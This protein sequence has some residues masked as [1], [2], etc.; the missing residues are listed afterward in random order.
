MSRRY[1]ERSREKP[2]E[3]DKRPSERII[4]EARAPVP[5]VVPH[6]IISSK[7][8]SLLTTRELATPANT[9]DPRDQKI[10]MPWETRDWALKRDKI[11]TSI[12]SF[13]DMDMRLAWAYGSDYRT[14]SFVEMMVVGTAAKT[15]GTAPHWP[16]DS[17]LLT[18]IF[19][20]IQRLC[21]EGPSVFKG[22]DARPLTRGRQG[23]ITLSRIQAATIVALMWFN[24]F[25]YKFLTPGPITCNDFPIASMIGIVD[26]KSLFPAT[27]IF[28]YFT[29]IYDLWPLPAPRGISSDIDTRIRD[30]GVLIREMRARKIII[31]RNVLVEPMN[32]FE[33]TEPICTVHYGDTLD[34]EDSIS[35]ICAAYTSRFIGGDF[36]TEALS[37]DEIIIAGRPE[38]MVARLFC[39]ETADNEAI[40]VLGAERYSAYLGTASNIVHKGRF[41]DKSPIGRMG[42]DAL[43]QHG[44]VF[45]D[46]GPKTRTM[47]QF[48][49]YFDRDLDK[50]YAGFTSNFPDGSQI[51]CTRWNYKWTIL[52]NSLK[53]LQLLLAASAAK[54]SLV[55]HADSREFE[56][57][58][59]YFLAWIKS[60]NLTVGQLA[61]RYAIAIK[62]EVAAN[63]L[64]ASID[65]FELIIGG[66]TI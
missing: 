9:Y 29:T 48:V 61:E 55:Y 14:K 57:K 22:F 59:A 32:W 66:D 12:N 41:D 38:L 37:S 27:C 17:D 8:S 28:E 19:P 11:N 62:G 26:N 6:G 24:Q 35:T 5:R 15:A 25:D 1:N 13:I 34:V 33:C 58:A 4:D 52:N 21:V 40:C 42:N 31:M 30:T 64:T 39:M 46:A 65:V 7:I 3:W 10:I 44:V 60:A 51:A 53:F 20:L 63:T 18:R 47:S 50:A 45:L 56:D 2:R 23:T 49:D 16:S 43:L 36:F 54:R